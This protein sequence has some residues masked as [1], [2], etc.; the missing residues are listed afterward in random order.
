MGPHTLDALG[1][2]LHAIARHPGAL[3]VAAFGAFGAFGADLQGE[4]YAGFLAAMAG[5]AGQPSERLT[6]PDG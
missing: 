5:K 2:L 6:P 4:R 3:A 1:Q